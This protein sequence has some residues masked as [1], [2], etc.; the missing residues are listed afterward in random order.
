MLASVNMLLERYGVVSRECAIGEG[1]PGGYS[2]YYRVLRALEESGHLRRGH[3]V[4]GLTGAQFALPDAVER[5]R[6]LRDGNGAA[7]E[8]TL[9]NALDP[10][11]PWGLLLPWPPL[12]LA[13]TRPRRLQGAWLVQV[14][15]R[16]VLHVSAGARQL[17]TFAGQDE[18]ALDA[19]FG[20]LSR[21][22]RGAR[23]RTMVVEFI[24][25]VPARESAFAS[26]LLALGFTPD[27]GGLMA[28][29][30]TWT[31]AGSGSA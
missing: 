18:G 16:P 25:G 14:N 15:G 6:G 22:P 19:G 2:P 7:G 13:H 10:A 1:L 20:A 11:N 23:R 21:L 17:L 29:P 31:D 26:R 4:A 9:L 5:L 27:Y 12:T 8:A 24:D 28:P 3:F 30:R